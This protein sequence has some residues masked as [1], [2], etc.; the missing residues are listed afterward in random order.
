M[1]ENCDILLKNLDIDCEIEYIKLALTH[2][3]F[4]SE[5]EISKE[6]S[7]ERLEFL[8]DAVLKIIV[9]EYLYN[10]YQ[11]YDEG[12]LSKIRSVVISDEVLEKVARK[13]SLQNFLILGKNEEKN[14]GRER[15]STIACAFEAFLGGLFL[16]GKY[17]ETK[18]LVL[19]L[20]KDEI[21]ETD[22]KGDLNNFKALLQEHCQA[23]YADIP[24]Y[25]TI[26][27]EGPAHAKTFYVVVEFHGKKLGEGSGSTK[28]AAQKKAAQQACRFL[29]L[30]K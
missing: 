12:H 16:A 7:N 8:G 19:D 26:G 9:S 3:S 6:Y 17:E 14:G 1:E 2:S 23:K 18:K 21:E 15:S 4:C 22:F 11:N 13:I 30:T 20:L 5:L 24:E 10:K 29:G 27:E 25:I 28:K